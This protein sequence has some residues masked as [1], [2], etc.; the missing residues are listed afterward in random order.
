MDTTTQGHEHEPVEIEQLFA[1]LC[2]DLAEEQDWLIRYTALT[3]EQ[4]KYAALVLRIKTARGQALAEG[5]AQ[6][7]QAAAAQGEPIGLTRA[8]ELVAEAAGLG[9]HQRVAQIEQAAAARPV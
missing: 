9:S 2:G 7:R 4:T 1:N 5:V 8:R 6:V 3:S